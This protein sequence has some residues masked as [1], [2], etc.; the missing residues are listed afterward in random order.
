LIVFTR[1]LCLFYSVRFRNDPT[2]TANTKSELH[3]YAELTLA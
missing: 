3:F 2:R 1:H